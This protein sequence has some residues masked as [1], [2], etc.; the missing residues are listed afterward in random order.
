MAKESPAE[1]N[2]KLEKL[3]ADIMGIS[4]NTLVIHLRFMY[5][6]IS[7]LKTQNVPGLGFMAVDGSTI[8]YDPLVLLKSFTKGK[9]K[10]VRQYLHMVLHCVFQ[11]F[12]V[13]TLVDQKYWN[14]ACD[15]AVEYTINDIGISDVDTGVATAQNREIERLKKHTKYITADMLYR[16]FMTS[17]PKGEEIDKLMKLFSADDHTIW[18]S[19]KKRE[20]LQKQSR[21]EAGKKEPAES[22]GR[23]SGE[24]DKVEGVISNKKTSDVA[25]TGLSDMSQ[26]EVDKMLDEWKEV[27]R[28]MKMDLE[29]FSR[30]RGNTASGLSQNLMAVT[31]EQYDYASFLRKFAVLGERMKI[32]IDEFDYIFYTY[33]LKVYENMPLIEPLEYKDVKQVREIAIAIDTSGSTSGELVQAFVQKTYNILKDE[34]SFSTRFN[35]HFIQCDAEIQEDVKITNQREFDD[36]LANMKIKGLG[37]TD[38]R[39]VFS[40]VDELIAEK[41]F[42]NLKGLIYFTDGY[43]E[44]PSR[45]PNYN[46]A[47]V[48]V[49]DGY[50]NPEVPVWAIKLVLQPD[51]IRG[52]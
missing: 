4:R 35:L 3:A 19:I 16:Y 11:H 30:E 9:N 41:E 42:V 36:Y 49:E 14:L 12:W 8:Y 2:I 32:N 26:Q 18:Y 13:S 31:R 24:I 33:G 23:K 20:E 6:A 22:A 1:K 39:P 48:F 38:F 37:G 5:K 40:Y 10:T 46:T 29:T 27:A 45:Q 47:F 25:E 34:E 7:M 21:K 15:I 17:M 52:I 50:N 44:F 43:G 28:Q 51:E